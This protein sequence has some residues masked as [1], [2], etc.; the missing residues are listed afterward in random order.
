MDDL[1]VTVIGRDLTIKG[2][3]KPQAADGT[4]HHRRERDAG[5]FHRTVRLPV[6][7]DAKKVKAE[8]RHGVL[9]VTLPKAL[10]AQPRKI[11]VKCLKG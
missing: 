4:T 2:H 11:E 5:S 6:D 1:E 9:T 3:R 7:I 10:E 8:L